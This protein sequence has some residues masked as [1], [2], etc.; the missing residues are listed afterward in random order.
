MNIVFA[1]DKNYAEHLAVSMCSLFVNN[2]SLSFDVY[3]VNADIDEKSWSGFEVLARRYGHNLIDVKIL[4][5]ELD[6]LITSHHFT[7]AN[8]YRL[9]IPEKLQIPKALYFDADIVINVDDCYLAAVVNPG[10]HRHKNLDMSSDSK[11]FNSGV[12]LI[13]LVA[14]RRDNIKGRV[15]DFVKR[16][17]WA[18][19]F[20]DQC[21][22][23]AVVDGQWEELH[24]KFN[25]QACLFEAKMGTFSA[26]FPNHDLIDAIQTPVVVHYSGSLKPWHFR[27]KHPW[28]KLYWKYLRMTPFNHLFSTDFTI[29]NVIKWYIPKSLKEVI[30][31][32]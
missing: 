7:K 24:P 25:L 20:V 31:R 8:Y 23:N 4:D 3:V 26:T 1:A 18:I 27:Y 30:K 16:K 12:M 11:Y 6:G 21:G 13:N 15:I 29:V 22:L 28:R 9:F 17:P 32:R 10:F 19:Q 14:W 5:Q 2:Q